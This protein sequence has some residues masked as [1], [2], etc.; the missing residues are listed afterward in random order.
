M[1][2]LKKLGKDHI[3]LI[4]CKQVELL[5]ECDFNDVGISMTEQTISSKRFRRM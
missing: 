1:E 5:A 4:D 2:Q 3:I